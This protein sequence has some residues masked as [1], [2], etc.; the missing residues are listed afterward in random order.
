MPQFEVTTLVS[1]LFEAQELE[2]LKPDVVIYD[3]QAGHPEAIFSLLETCPRLL[4]NSNQIGGY[5]AR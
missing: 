1:P 2:A 5:I 4:L 3:L